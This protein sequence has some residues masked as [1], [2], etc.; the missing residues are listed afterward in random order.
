MTSGLG[1]PHIVQVFDFSSMPTGEP[2]LV[3]EFLEGEDLDQRLRRD[4]RLSPTSTLRIIKQVAS[5]LAATHAKKIVHRDLK[6]A[7]IYLLAA[8][9][10][11][12]FVKVLDFGI[13]KVR[14]ATTKLTRAESVMGTPDYMSPEQALGAIDEID[15]R[16]DQWALACITWECLSGRAP[17]IGENVPS[18]L[19]QVVHEQPPPLAPKVPGL[20]PEVEEVLLRA[21]SKKKADRF[22]SVSAF[23]A[24]LNLSV[25]GHPGDLGEVAT[26]PQTERLP[27]V[28]D[29][30]AASS[31]AKISTTFTQTAGE[32]GS[33]LD[34][35]APPSRWI[36][37][38]AGLLI[39]LL[40]T[41]FF[42]LRPRARSVAAPT[43]P[44]PPAMPA[45]PV[46]VPAS[47][48]S[49][50][51]PPTSVTAAEPHAA[52]V[53]AAEKPTAGQRPG[54]QAAHP[55]HNKAKGPARQKDTSGP[56]TSPSSRPKVERKLIE[57]L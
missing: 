19:F 24:A 5:A 26:S 44:T 39:V 9:E 3:M 41:G 46:P 6:P 31:T 48:G 45:Q 35:P 53:S 50:A 30:K 2:F 8:A 20:S 34:R 32:L 51:I 40:G 22:P 1:H 12:D 49:S 25:S 38:A 47:L 7:N 57:D 54:N 36:W 4:R 13:S 37:A 21:L 55:R 33:K 29:S 28:E 27:A 18:L 11:A 10:E 17:F 52:G 15:E 14:A 16:T 23:A 56:A 42:L 43:P